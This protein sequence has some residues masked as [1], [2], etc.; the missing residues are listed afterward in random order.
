MF[1][2]SAGLAVLVPQVQSY[3]HE[4]RTYR[5]L[6]KLPHPVKVT[7][8][9]KAPAWLRPFGAERY[10]QRIVGVELADCD[11]DALALLAGLPALESLQV[12]SAMVTDNGLKRIE[13][14]G[15]LFHLALYSPNISDRGL[16]SLARLSGLGWLTLTTP[17]VTD[18]GLKSLANLKELRDLEIESPKVGDNGMRH[19]GGLALWHLKVFAPVSDRGLAPLVEERNLQ[20]SSN[21]LP[22]RQSVVCARPGRRRLVEVLREKTEC[23]FKEQPL[24]D[25]LEYIGARHEISLSTVDDLK[26]AG[27]DPLTPITFKAHGYSLYHQLNDLLPPVGLDWRMGSTTDIEVLPQ[28]TLSPQRPNLLKLRTRRPDCPVIVDW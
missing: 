5:E 13:G 28:A 21:Q 12:H 10:M 14:C 8:A 3:R 23:D 19:L 27:I 1:V 4:W 26:K 22:E 17:Q 25:V 9:P 18:A 11:D 16:E 7:M 20:W 2:C 24:C 6:N 15:S